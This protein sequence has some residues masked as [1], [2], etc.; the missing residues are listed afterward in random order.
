[1]YDHVHWTV[2]DCK[3]VPK[4]YDKSLAV[5][6]VLDEKSQFKH[7]E[8]YLMGRTC[9]GVFDDL[10]GPIS[11]DMYQKFGGI[12]YNSFRNKIYRDY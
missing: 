1:M 8:I 11:F 2:V 3:A 10:Y 6:T 7:G 4:P 12:I 9:K 5:L